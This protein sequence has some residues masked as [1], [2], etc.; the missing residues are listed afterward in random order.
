M[1][2]LNLKE[3]TEKDKKPPCNGPVY[4]ASVRSYIGSGKN[5]QKDRLNFHVQLNRLKRKSCP[6]CEQCGYIYD[7][8]NEIVENDEIEGVCDVEDKKLYRFEFVADG[9]DYEGGY[10]DDWHLKLVELKEG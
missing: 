2:F 4:R 7:Y 8:L 6:G 5:G 9:Y 10:C 1:L 3:E